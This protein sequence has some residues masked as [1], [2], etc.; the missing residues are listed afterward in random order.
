M[1]DRPISG[2]GARLVSRTVTSA[3]GTAV[4]Y[5]STGRGPGVIVVPG[6]LAEAADLNGL[7]ALLADAGHEAHVVQRRGRGASGPQ[8]ASY[9][10]ERE[11][12]DVAA[13]RAATGARML[14]GHSYGG[15]VALR[16]ACG[17]PRYEAVAVYEPGVSVEGS[18]PLGWIGRA[19]RE[20]AAGEAFEAFVT[21]VRGVNP[22]Q[23]GRLPRFLLKAVLRLA[24]PKKDLRRN[25][26][27][28]PQAV[29]EHAE[30]L[31]MEPHLADY[32]RIGAPVLLLRGKGQGGDWQVA[33][34]ARLERE[35]PRARTVALPRLDHF[36]PEKKPE[37][38]AAALVPFLAT[39]TPANS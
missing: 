18:I 29:R 35:I 7:A 5:L 23:S 6:A 25:L 10:I 19:S 30:V 22:E 33:A 3:D 2:G 38:V 16:A 27:L 34:L 1:S 36:A 21:F 28:M 12:E 13:V 11:C 32:R 37:E 20:V 31:R 39:R 17:D 24:I 14:F 9:G 8:G 26:A 15:L 4:E